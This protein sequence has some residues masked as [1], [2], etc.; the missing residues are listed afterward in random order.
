MAGLGSIEPDRADGVAPEIDTSK[1][2]PARM[3]DYLLGGK[4]N[5][6]ADR[7]TAQRALQA[8][9]T[10]RTAARENRA[11]VGR[12]VRY[13]AE[14]AG[15]TQFLDLGSGLP[16]VGNVHEVAQDVVPSAHVVYVDNDPIVLAHGRALLASKPEGK[17]AYIHA[18]IRD[19][20][21][22]LANPVTRETLD[23]SQP[24]ALVIAAVLHFVPD[25][26][27]PGRIISTLVDALPSG[28]YVIASHGTAEYS[29]EGTAGLVRAYAQGGIPGKARTADE[30]A[31]LAFSGLTLVP[32]GVVLVSEWRP[33]PGAIPPLAA[34]VGSNGGIG[35][36]P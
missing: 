25:E 29:P 36:K 35:R 15:I 34:E 3:Y 20:Q 30:F 24:I 4:D 27:E 23:F 7:E 17:C 22:I 18:D 16:G 26:H 28:S 2:H 33:E 10:I 19:P 31:D 8:W 12:A 21:A 5:F 6:A 1:P 32:P 13:L 11:F 9:P 14:E